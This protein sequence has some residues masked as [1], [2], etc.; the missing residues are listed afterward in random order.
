MIVI[1]PEGKTPFNRQMVNDVSTSSL[2]ESAG[3]ALRRLS[4]ASIA[5]FVGHVLLVLM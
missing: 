1:P 5:T 3:P 2:I 4:L